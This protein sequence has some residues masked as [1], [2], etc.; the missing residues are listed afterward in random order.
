MNSVESIEPD[1]LYNIYVQKYGENSLSYL[2]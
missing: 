1:N 2:M